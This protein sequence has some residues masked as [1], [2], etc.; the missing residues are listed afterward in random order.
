MRQLLTVVV[1]GAALVSGASAWAQ[2]GAVS[3][4]NGEINFLSFKADGEGFENKGRYGV[5]Q[6]NTP[7]THFSGLNLMA[8]RG[9]AKVSGVTEYEY[10]D[11]V[12][13]ISPFLRDP[14]FGMIGL[15]YGRGH[16]TFNR[17]HA[18]LRTRDMGAL[19]AAYSSV[20]SLAASYL[21]SEARDG[22]GR[23]ITVGYVALVWYT[24]PNFLIDISRGFKDAKRTN[25]LTLEQQVGQS[26]FSYGVSYSRNSDDRTKAVSLLLNYRLG[27]P[28]TLIKRYHED[29]YSHR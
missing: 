12:Y 22:S 16:T 7:L 9:S 28:K 15:S 17:T 13:S 23:D 11:T 27:A 5:V 1:T 18:D 24:D 20:A 25:G 26:G 19:A 2:Q 21:K 6:A 29:L 3:G 4:F 14:D 8:E 10:D